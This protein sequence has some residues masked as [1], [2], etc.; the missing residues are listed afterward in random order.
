M[1]RNALATLVLSGMAASASAAPWDKGAIIE[2]GIT[3][4]DNIFLNEAGSEESEVIYSLSPEFFLRKED[5]RLTANLRY[6]PQAFFFSDF[7]DSDQVF[8]TLDASLTADMVPDRFFVFLNAVNFQSIETADE[9][10]PTTNLPITNNRIDARILSVRPYWQQRIGSAS[11]LL[12]AGFQDLDYDDSRFQALQE[13]SGRFRLNN[14]EQRDGI[15]WGM[16]FDYRRL[17]YDVSAPFDFQRAGANLGY[18]FGGRFRLF[19][20]GGAETSVDNLFEPNLDEDFWEVGFQY[21]PSERLNL[22]LAAGERGYGDAYR[23]NFSY[24]LRRGDISLTYSES[25]TARGQAVFGTRPLVDTDN[26]DNFLDRPGLADRFVRKRADFSTRI[27]L[28]RSTLTLRIFAEDREG[29]ID[30]L[31]GA[32]PNETLSGIAVRWTWNLGSRTTFGVAADLAE[33]EDGV[34]DSE[35]Q[36]AVIDLSYR[37]SRRLSLRLEAS[38]AEQEGLITIGTGYVENQVRLVLR[39]EI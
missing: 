10:F 14:L 24:R 1:Q 6:R 34:Q 33:R 28:A 3:S 26:L 25:P 7:N 12:E 27:D 17:E 9:V 36:R 2:A 21:T 11:I 5:E 32:L 16:S 29:R 39:T 35:L 4:T 18:W 19:A 30:D 22:E 37:L 13:T 23:G 38:R 31:G 8:H 15:A 20:G